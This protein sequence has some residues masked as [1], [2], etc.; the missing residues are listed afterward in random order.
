MSDSSVEISCAF[1]QCKNF[2]NL[3]R[4]DKVTETFK[5]GTFLRHS[6]DRKSTGAIV[7]APVSGLDM[8]LGCEPTSSVSSVLDR[9]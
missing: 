5:M 2:E 7:D 1:K 9:D 6:V 3:S 8:T 4:F